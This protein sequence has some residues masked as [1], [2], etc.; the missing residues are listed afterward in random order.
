MLA[1]P[2]CPS[3]AD[4]PDVVAGAGEGA[5]H[6]AGQGALAGLTPAWAACA[7]AGIFPATFPL[8]IVG[9]AVSAG[10]APLGA[11]VGA[12]VGAAR[13]SSAEEVD[14]AE[15]TMKEALSDFEM[16]RSLETRIVQSG[17]ALTQAQFFACTVE[18]GGRPLFPYRGIEPCAGEDGSRPDA[19]LTIRRLVAAFPSSRGLS[20]DVPMV[21]TVDACVT[22]EPDGEQL[23]AGLWRDRGPDEDFFEMVDDDAAGF[24]GQL[25][26]AADAMADAIVRDAFV[27]PPRPVTS[28]QQAPSAEKQVPGTVLQIAAPGMEP[29]G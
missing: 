27:G 11:I 5:L 20:P 16:A 3:T 18:P 1:P 14:A 19:I 25:A 12:V 21:V 7:A 4:H 26:R 22:K 9:I 10:T 29:E 6:G 23:Y 8:C 24:R 28:A 2:S 13:A 15:A 17:Q